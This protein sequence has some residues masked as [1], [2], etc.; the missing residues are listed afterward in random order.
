MCCD[1]QTARSSRH[2][3]KTLD[4]KIMTNW[5]MMEMLTADRLALKLKGPKK[6]FLCSVNH[7]QPNKNIR[8]SHTGQ[9]HHYVNQ[10]AGKETLPPASS[11]YQHSLN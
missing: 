6:P 8:N 2:F 7:L 11:S 4:L 3:Q 5:T 10:K 9:R 1:L